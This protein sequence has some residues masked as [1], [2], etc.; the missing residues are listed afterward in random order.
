MALAER[1]WER[2]G[3]RKRD[4][5]RLIESAVVIM[6]FG[7]MWDYHEQSCMCELS[8]L[9]VECLLNTAFYY[10]INM[11]LFRDHFQLTLELQFQITSNAKKTSIT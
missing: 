10:N 3:E 8:H 7:H 11:V 2:V 5:A 9:L 6:M 1:T 4:R